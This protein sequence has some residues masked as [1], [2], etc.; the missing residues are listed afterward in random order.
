MAHA[1]PPLALVV[2]ARNESRSLARCLISAAPW[3]DRMLVV[4]TGSTDG[5]PAIAAACG[6]EV[7]HFPWVNDFSA[8]R[9]RAL[10]LA[11]A[12]WNLILDADEWIAS[13]GEALRT[14][15]Q[16][17]ARLGV[18]CIESEYDAATSREETGHAH[19]RSWM[20][21]L[22]PRGARYRGRVHEQVDSPLPR[23]R[24]DLHLGHD[25][26]RDAQMTAK[27]DRNRPLLLLDLQD[28]PDDP[29]ILYQLGK[30]AEVHG[31]SARAC[32]W[33]AQAARHTP[34]NANWMHELSVRHLHCLGQAGRRAE[35]LASAE[36]QLQ[37][38]ADSPDFFFTLGN[39]LLDQALADPAQAM[40][41]WLPLAETA[42]QRCLEIGERPDLEGSVHGRGS[43]LAQHNLNI[44]LSNAARQ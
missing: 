15:T 11:G 20:T 43:H 29:Y 16:G 13:G 36:A 27:R 7:H 4:D 37:R 41:H 19:N 23:Q 3:V 31:D 14:W 2:I 42:W 28:H 24:I 5:T 18:V 25:G 26:Y 38:W 6:A 22:L 21:R 39:L 30:D 17:P 9:N 10:D 1:C 12:D 8:A 44:I 34:E 40:D 35:A 32:D 33:Y